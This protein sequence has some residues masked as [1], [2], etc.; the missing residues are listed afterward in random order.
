MG[1]KNAEEW[2]RRSSLSHRPAVGGE[3]R[4]TGFKVRRLRDSAGS[5]S[6]GLTR[7]RIHYRKAIDF[8]DGL[9]DNQRPHAIGTHVAWVAGTASRQYRLVEKGNEH[10]HQHR[11]QNKEND[12]NHRINFLILAGLIAFAAWWA[13]H[14][15]RISRRDN[16][17]P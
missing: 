14:Q 4:K 11:H 8:H 5:A 1:T 16:R 6:L 17:K 3:K 10:R 15:N 2:Q 9:M 12:S 7:V 13:P